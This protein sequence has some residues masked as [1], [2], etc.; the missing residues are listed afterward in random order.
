MRLANVQERPFFAEP[1]GP[2]CPDLTLAYDGIG[3]ALVS[4]MEVE[5]RARLLV[6][7]QL[8]VWWTSPAADALIGRAGALL[9]RSG[10]VHTSDKRFDRQLRELIAC[11]KGELSIQCIPDPRRGEHLVITAQRLSPPSHHLVGLT[12]QSVTDDFG[13]RLADLHQAFGFTPTEE[14]VAHHLLCGRT[15]DETAQHL[16]VSLET[17]RTHIK[18]SYVKLG[19]SSREAF[20]HRLTP[21][22][23]PV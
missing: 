16:N 11:A 14:R 2:S 22:M 3:E 12:L 7:D 6:D 1:R 8:R 15:A 9:I 18:R 23:V 19:V 5:Q 13:F 17:V 21:F 4:W 10:H 20:F